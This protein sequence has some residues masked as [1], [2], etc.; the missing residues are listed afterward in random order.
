MDLGGNSSAG[1][2][3]KQDSEL[4]HG[5]GAVEKRINNLEG[6]MDLLDSFA[7]TDDI[8]NW[9][10]GREKS[11]TKVADMWNFI[12]FQKRVEASEN[13]VQKV[14]HLLSKIERVGML[15]VENGLKVV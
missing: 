5:G 3:L 6:K 11:T 7:G 1:I 2:K 9:A 14:Q 8:M 10:R 4:F 13:G 12:N 15:L